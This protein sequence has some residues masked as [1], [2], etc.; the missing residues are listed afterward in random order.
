MTPVRKGALPADQRLETGPLTVPNTISNIPNPGLA[1][2]VLLIRK[3]SQY[4]VELQ[5]VLVHST[6]AF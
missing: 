3:H 1:G 5:A 2:P 6:G 4:P